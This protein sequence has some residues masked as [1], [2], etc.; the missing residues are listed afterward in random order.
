MLFD[1][2]KLSEVRN[3]YY[4][5]TSRDLSSGNTKTITNHRPTSTSSNGIGITFKIVSDST[6][7]GGI[8]DHQ[9]YD[10]KG[11]ISF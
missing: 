6:H 4:Q 2:A 5:Y 11:E 3:A 10:H 1:G 9:N 8:K 7:A